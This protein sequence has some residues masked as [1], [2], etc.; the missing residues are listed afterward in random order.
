MNFFN[1]VIIY[2]NFHTAPDVTF[3]GCY[4]PH[5]DSQYFNIDVFASLQAALLNNGR[6]CILMGDLDAKIRNRHKILKCT[7]YASYIPGEKL[8]NGYIE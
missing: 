3:C 5:A 6:K 1:D 7:D 4:S 8:G 2:V